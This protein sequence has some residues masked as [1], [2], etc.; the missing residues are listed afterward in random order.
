MSDIFKRISDAIKSGGESEILQFGKYFTI[1]KKLGSG[2]QGIVV[3]AKAQDGKQF[4]IKFYS[5]TDNGTEITK[6]GKERFIREAKIL[7]KL[8]HRGIVNLYTAGSAR[9]DEGSKAWEVSTNFVEPGELL[10]Y[11]MDYVK[12]RNLKSLF[13]KRTK[14]YQVDP[15]NSIYR[16]QDLFEQLILQMSDAMSFFHRNKITHR[17]IKPEN[18]IYSQ[19][20]NTF[21]IVDFGFAKKHKR[22]LS[23]SYQE[24][25]IRKRYIDLDSENKGIVD[26]VSDQYM[27]AK[28][29]LEILE[30]FK[31]L[32]LDYNYSGI[33]ASLEKGASH[34]RDDRYKNMGEFKMAVEPYLY[35]HPY[36]GYNFYI[37]SF[38]SPLTRFGHFSSKIRIPFSGSI[39]VFKEVLEVIDTD[40][41]QR[42]RGVHQLGPTHF[43]YPGAIHSRFEHSLGTYALSLKYLEVLLGNS[44]FYEAIKPIE[45]AVK[46]VVLASLLHDIGHYPYSHWIEEIKGLPNGINFVRHEDRAKHIIE[47]GQ[48]GEIIKKNWEVEPAEVCKLITGGQLLPR[49]ELMRS[50]VD[51]VIDVDKMDYLQRDAAHCG[52]PYGSA[53]DIERIISSLYINEDHN[54]ICLTEK[55][56]SCFVAL[57]MCNMVMYQ[58]VYWHKT[59]R[60]CTAMF[61]RF[62]YEFLNEEI[63]DINKVKEEYLLYPDEKFV[64]T[65]FSK[66]RT[67]KKLNRLIRPFTNRARDLYKPAYVHYHGH[68]MHIKNEST[69]DFFAMLVEG[70]YPIQL[71]LTQ[72]LIDELKG[73]IPQIELIDVILETTPIRYREVADLKGLQLFD[74]QLGEYEEAPPEVTTL[75]AFLDT[76]RRSYIFCAREYYDQI[77]SLSRNGTLRTIFGK[78][79]ERKRSEK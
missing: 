21:V 5:L 28:M 17:D 9:W 35:S 8:K 10:Y 53:F 73:Y 6:K 51:S 19:D 7:L 71:E 65:L 69:K 78:V 42:L 72:Y 33:R 30:L 50:M 76:N 54:K 23:P 38:L 39:P 75:N 74:S 14:N 34:D 44:L 57:F 24:M 32:Y 41:F 18:I 22:K 40:D 64:D 25:I 1:I 59:V 46:L 60:A 58:E 36:H 31:T 3:L 26:H 56:R 20:D 27:F 43:V 29:L 2:Q 47:R 12:G 4:A 16:N 68:K 66:T 79:V 11:V 52:V 70:T 45:E 48:I 55:G 62:F 49:Q 61:K 13:Y 63:V 37:G 67:H 15:S 77:R